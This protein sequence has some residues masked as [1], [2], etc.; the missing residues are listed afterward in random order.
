MKL[1][2]KDWALLSAAQD[3]AKGIQKS[4]SLRL[5]SEPE[6]VLKLLEGRVHEIASKRSMTKG[7]VS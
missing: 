2:D 5:P 6:Y 4:D 7:R 3:V 1:T